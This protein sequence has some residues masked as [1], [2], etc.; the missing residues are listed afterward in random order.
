M[1]GRFFAI[2]QSAIRD[3]SC[4][5][6]D[7]RLSGLNTCCQP[8]Q[9]IL[10]IRSIPLKR[11]L[12]GGYSLTRSQFNQKRIMSAWTATTLNPRVKKYLYGYKFNNKKEY[13]ECLSGILIQAWQNGLAKTG[14]LQS[15]L[16]RFQP[17]SV[18]VIV[19]PPHAGK[20]SKIEDYAKHFA[21]HFGYGYYP[22][23]LQWQRDVSS[24]H[25]LQERRERF[26]N[27]QSSLVLQTAPNHPRP[28]LVLIID[29]LLT[30]G[31]T[32]LEARR[33]IV[34]GAAIQ[35]NIEVMALTLSQVPMRSFR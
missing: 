32:L 30:T 17:N 12:V 14:E 15:T 5:I 35:A 28:V 23:A 11:Q 21:Y 7:E 34:E 1:I 27:V 13:A 24:Q 33:A 22:N 16:N 6:C 19:I 8:C 31:A 3:Q 20:K 9:E 18:H 29:D 10:G 4:L 2:L 26:R 25:S